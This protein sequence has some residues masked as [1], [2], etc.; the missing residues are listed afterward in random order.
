MRRRLP[1]T[2]NDG[3]TVC[4]LCLHIRA[5][6]VCFCFLDRSTRLCLC[7]LA[8]KTRHRRNLAQEGAF[9]LRIT[10]AKHRTHQPVLSAVGCLRIVDTP[11]TTPVGLVKTGVQT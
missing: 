8:L 7:T 1:G 2:I 6:R 5:S 11:R 9:C 10:S 3:S 4:G